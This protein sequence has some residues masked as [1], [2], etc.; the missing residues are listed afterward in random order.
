MGAYGTPGSNGGDGVANWEDCVHCGLCLSACPTYQVTGLEMES[1]RGRLVLLNQWREQPEAHDVETRGWLDDCLDCR[2]CESVCPS[3]IPTGHL[4][5]AW[6]SQE[7]REARPP[8]SLLQVLELLLGSPRG[9]AWFRRMARWSQTRWGDWMV[10][11]TARWLPPG[12]RSVKAGLP[13]LHS[14]GLSRRRLDSDGTGSDIFFFVGCV[15]DALYSE[16]NEHAAD[17]LRLAGHR[18]T[19][20]QGQ[21]CCGAVHRHSGSPETA[22]HWA[23]AN[24]SLFEQSGAEVVAVD[25]AGCGAAL[26]E[27]ASL[28]PPDSP[29]QERAQHFQNA[30]QDVVQLLA[31]SLP[32]LSQQDANP[33]TVHDPCHHVHAQGIAKETRSLLGRAGYAVTEMRESTLCC[34]SAG[35]YNL[36]HPDKSQPLLTRKLA[37]IP[38][39]ATYVA[40]ANPGCLMHMQSG[41]S[42]QSHKQ[43]VHPVDLAWQAYRDAGLCATRSVTS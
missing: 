36:T 10:R 2:A 1:P 23:E 14:R 12:A 7:A 29:W 5:E 20:P 4:V 35:I 42:A 34:G 33:V 37:Q 43:V 17:L 40:A 6:R 3:N 15:M 28:F 31:D 27:Y 16:T 32:P 39:D 22:R 11:H 21:R 8:R 38:D 26:K 19:I 13:A 41:L 9:L 30:V 25:A 24:I 18:L